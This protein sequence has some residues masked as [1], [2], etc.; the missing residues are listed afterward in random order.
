M[1]HDLYID[2][3]RAVLARGHASSVVIQRAL[4][5]KYNDAASFILRMEAEGFLSKPD[6]DGRRKIIGSVE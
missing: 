6:S 5:V 3:K 4:G 1:N 2:A